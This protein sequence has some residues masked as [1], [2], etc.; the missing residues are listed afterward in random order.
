MVL[1]GLVTTCFDNN[2]AGIHNF[3]TSNVLEANEKSVKF[4]ICAALRKLVATMWHA[5][6]RDRMGP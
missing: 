3:G 6:I 1:F 5:V 2:Y 4:S